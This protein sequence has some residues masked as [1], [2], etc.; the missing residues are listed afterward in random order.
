MT[1]TSG[2]QTTSFAY[3]AAGNLTTT[4]LPSGNGHVGTNTYDRAGRRTTVEN[5]KSGTIL[6]RF[7]WTLDPAGNPTKAQTTRGVTDTYDAYEYDTRNRLTASCFGIASTA[8]NCTGAANTISYAYDKVSNRSQEVR[9]GSVG[10]TGTIDYVYNTADQLTSTT[11]GGATT[12]YTYDAN[13]NQTANSG[14]SYSYDLANRLTS[15]TSGGTTTTFGYDGDGM[16]A[17][18]ATAGGTDLRLRWDPLAP[19]GIPELALERDST[20]TL[21]R[22]YVGGPEGALAFANA[23]GSFWYHRDPLMSITDVTGAS[24][25]A[26]WRYEYEAYGAQRAATNVSG[27]APVNPSRFAGQYFDS[28]TALY[29]LRARDY[30]PESGRFTAVD[31]LEPSA[32]SPTESAYAYVGGRPTTAVDPYGTT[33]ISLSRPVTEPLASSVGTASASIPARPL[34]FYVEANSDGDALAELSEQG[35]CFLAEGIR[36]RFFAA[37]CSSWWRDFVTCMSYHMGWDCAKALYKCRPFIGMPLIG[38]TL[39]TACVTT[40]CGRDAFR[41]IKRCKRYL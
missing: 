10:N 40:R 39:F 23:S 16:R 5:A 6:S 11:K 14:R 29:H 31:P 1:V 15:S 30:V 26:Q 20:G 13:G 33:A 19:A 7:L 3:D 36:D 4:T 8:T 32:S 35:R 37:K 34:P 27:A 24:G 18:A 9:T 12:N 28:D 2:G 25:A 38:T 22:R 21:V 17:K 41:A